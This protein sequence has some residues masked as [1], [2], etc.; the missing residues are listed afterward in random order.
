MVYVSL[1]YYLFV[2][3][4]V[5]VYYFLPVKYRWLALL[6]GS[7]GFYGILCPA[8]F[9]LFLASIVLGWLAG[10]GLDC[11]KEKGRPRLRQGLLLAGILLALLPLL[12][13]K[14][15]GLRAP[16]LPLMGLSFYSL[17]TVAY[18]VDV[19]QGKIEAQRN[20]LYYALFASFF[21][22][23][24]Q[25]PIPRYE[26]LGPQLL[27]GH[28]FDSRNFS[29][30][31]QLIVWGFF[32]KFM[33][34]DKAGVF[35]DAVFDGFP[36]R[37][38]CY[39]LVAGVLYSLQLYTDF[40]ACVT[41]SQGVAELFGIRLARNFDH[42]YWSRSIREFWRRW[43]ISLS[44]WLRDYI[45]IPL[46]GSR[47]GRLLKYINLIAVFAVSGLWHGLGWKFLVWGLIHAVYQ[48]TGDL[49][50]PLKAKIYKF[51]S[52]PKDSLAQRA[53]QTAGTFF[54]V[55][56]AWIVFRA[57]TLE[58]AVNM[59]RSMFGFYNPWILYDGSLFDLGLSGREWFLLLMA[60]VAL[61]AIGLRQRLGGVRDWILE[62]HMI[63]RWLIYFTAIGL[64]WLYGTYGFGFAQDFIYGG[65]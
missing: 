17:Q 42:P 16:W 2:A 61:W 13:A 52:I 63:I 54:W 49:L 11:L 50:G 22:Q 20:P 39:I 27:E 29:K 4:L 32:L 25:G 58:T 30:G 5:A 51:L 35:V 10:F 57:D 3:A 21:P 37:Q 23:I 40:L 6:A 43:H 65:F 36:I 60:T 41:L 47:R 46:G 31:L 24:I 7:L 26:Q 28:L 53:A 12:A 64:I 34:A 62:Q 14:F 8:G 59:I 33:L 56:L 38:G 15:P 9:P 45:Y 48:I 18:L 55:M 44:T 1:N 19:Y